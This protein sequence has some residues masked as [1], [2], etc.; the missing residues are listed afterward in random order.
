[1]PFYRAPAHRIVLKAAGFDGKIPLVQDGKWNTQVQILLFYGK[2]AAVIERVI[3]GQKWQAPQFH[4][5]Y[6]LVIDALVPMRTPIERAERGETTLS[7]FFVE[8]LACKAEWKRLR[9]AGNAI[10]SELL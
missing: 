4:D 2:N 7:E 8:Q 3:I 9:G 1:M 5:H 10:A 6:N